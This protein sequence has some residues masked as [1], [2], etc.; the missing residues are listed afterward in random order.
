MSSCARWAER[1]GKM[2]T[3][4]GKV[5]ARV[6]SVLRPFLV[7]HPAA[8]QEVSAS[9]FDGVSRKRKSDTPAYLES[10]QKKLEK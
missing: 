5:L 1:A 6:R 8:F 7:M 10:G 9:P 2:R 3:R 4:D